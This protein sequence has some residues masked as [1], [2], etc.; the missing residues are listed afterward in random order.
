MLFLKTNEIWNVLEEAYIP[1]GEGT[2]GK[3]TQN[4]VVGG[5]DSQGSDATNALST[6]ALDAYA[7]VRTVQPNFGVRY[8]E[9]SPELFFM[10]AV[11]YAKDGVL[12]HFFNDESIVQSLVA[13]GHLLEDARDYGLVGCLE[14]NSQGLFF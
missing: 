13:G 3:T 1:G 2:E 14:P 5:M 11:N 9:T 7:Q 6:L 12:L 10:R 8:S 4:V